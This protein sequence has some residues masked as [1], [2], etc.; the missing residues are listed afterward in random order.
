M[1]GPPAQSLGVE[2]V[3]PAVMTRPPRPRNARVLTSALIQRVLQSASIIML[4]T[5]FT[6]IH[7][8]AD[9]RVVTARDTTMT[10]TCFVL[11]DMFNAL[12]CRSEAKSFL[13]GEVGVLDNKMFNIAVAGSLAGQAAVVYVPPLQRIFQTEA[14]GLGDWVRLVVIAS[15]VLWVDEGRKWLKR[16]K[17]SRGVGR[18]Y[19]TNV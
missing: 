9:G 4:G 12:T 17:A 5:L 8:M 6:Y 13:W 18:G 7:E 19:S 15:C 10:F 3:D 2:P 14:L 11:F 1:D 16:R